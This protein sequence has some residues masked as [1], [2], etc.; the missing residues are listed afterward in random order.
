MS[1]IYFKYPTKFVGITTK[2]S[3]SH[4]G[5]DLGWN[6]NYGGKNAPIYSASAGYVDSI[7]TTGS[8]GN[9]VTVRRN[10]K[11]NNCTWYFKYKHLSKISV[12]KGQNVNIYTK[13]GNMGNT[14]GNYS[15]HLHFDVVRCPY[16]YKYTQTDSARKKYSVNPTK[17]VYL[18]PD[19]AVGDSAKLVKKY[20]PKTKLT[21]TVGNY[22]C[23]Y[24]MNI[25]T[26][27]GTSYR[28]KKVKEL[29][30]DGRSHA[31]SKNLNDPACYKKGTIF[32]ASK[33]LKA[34]DG[35][36]WG[37]SPSGYICI[38]GKTTTYCKKV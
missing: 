7:T 34:K 18:Y 33:I 23:L 22:K 31:T 19:Q 26:G 14:G 20:T 10:D 25:R 32:T 8:A 35:S 38:K 11:A 36:I 3:S 28:R 24:N 17:Y 4:L 15:N 27:A 29:T 21:Y 2:F 12:K 9:C 16:G 13:I 37:K 5:I 30:A 1:T 6:N